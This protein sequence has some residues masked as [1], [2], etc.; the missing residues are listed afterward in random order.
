M[1]R[2][3]IGQQSFEVLRERNCVYVDKTRFIEEIISTGSQYYF[4]GRPRRFGKS[5][6]LST[7]KFFFQGRRDLFKGLYADTMD[8]DWTPH[9]VLYI[10]LNIETYS[11]ER[12]LDDVLDS[13]L[14]GWEAEYDVTE[15]SENISV[16]FSNIIKAACRKT[17]KKVV[18]LVDEYDK[19]LVGNLND[20]EMFE[21]YRKKLASLYSNFKSSADYI[22]LVFLTGVSRFGH[23]SVFS[24]LNNIM[25]IS[26]DNQF[27]DICGIT[28]DELTDNFAEGIQELSRAHGKTPDEIKA[29]LKKWYDGYR[30]SSRGRDIYN[31][32]SIV[33]VMGTKEFDNYWIQSGQATLL[34][35]QLRRFDVDLK[36]LFNAECEIEELRGL[37]LDNPRPV[38]LLYQTGYL[39][40]K[41]YADGLYTLG[42]PNQ[43]VKR[44]FLLYLLPAYAN[45]NNNS[46]SFV[47]RNF[48]AELKAGDAEAFMTRLTSM[49]AAVPYDMN[50]D[51][52]Q[53]LHN[54][55]LILMMLIGIDVRTE[56]RTS[57][58]R[59]DLF[60]KTDRYYYIMELKLNR[61]ARE[62]LDQIND[63]DYALPF[64]T[65][66]RE[67]IRIGISF[68]SEARTIT[69]WI[70]QA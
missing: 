3:G 62:A 67:I 36:S 34:K 25:D 57:K 52:E 46:S 29:L 23:R 58:G 8:W 55:L 63:R 33:Y 26:F 30:F 38:A 45:L 6:F 41:S 24:G 54:A 14:K 5:L 9:P 42:I 70:I 49:F 60:I 15:E 21:F 17:G 32:F 61:P 28:E 65:D 37:D 59:I 44:S 16:R 19:P 7:L 43:E 48:L 2:Y 18:I 22:R 4:L 13:M 12:D 1:V 68:S 20:S 27:S 50:M 69:N 53:N 39:T 11:S 31:P 64:A 56:Y 40:I 66:G 35:E 51:R 10:D 47:L